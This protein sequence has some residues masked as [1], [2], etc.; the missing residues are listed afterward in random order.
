MPT[1]SL[2]QMEGRSKAPSCKESYAGNGF[3]ALHSADTS[4][5][6]RSFTDMPLNKAIGSKTI[7]DA[8]GYTRRHCKA[9]L[10]AGN[11]RLS[12]LVRKS[13]IDKPAVKYSGRYFRPSAK[14]QSYLGGVDVLISKVLMMVDQRPLLL[15]AKKA[16]VGRDVPSDFGPTARGV[17]FMHMHDLKLEVRDYIK[18]LRFPHTCI[19]VGANTLMT[20]KNYAGNRAQKLVYSTL[21]TTA[22][23]VAHIIVDSRTLNQTVVAYDG[24]TSISET[25]KIA[26]KVIGEDFSDYPR[27]AW[28]DCC[29]HHTLTRVKL[30]SLFVRGNTTV[31]R[32][33]AS[34]CLDSRRLYDGMPYPNVE[35]EE[36][37]YYASGFVLDYGPEEVIYKS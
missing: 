26:K 7:P 5:E 23:M 29:I 4:H 6:K 28:I 32:A 18:E 27:L 1:P 19:E 10:Q 11:F 35:E 22:R 31:A 34:G 3:R 20:Q 36:K 12:I 37:T 2:S 17:M 30:K 9:L 25:W 14:L 15:A 21:S 33:K 24:E 8:S 13:S 16:G